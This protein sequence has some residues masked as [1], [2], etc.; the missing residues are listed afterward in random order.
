[1]PDRVVRD[2]I[3]D[4][5]RINELSFPAE[6]FYRRL[7]SVA[8]DYGRYEARPSLL[9][10]KLFPVRPD[11]SLVTT[12]QVEIWMYECARQQVIRLY[13]IEG[14][15]FLEIRNFGQRLRSMKS[16]YPAPP[17]DGECLTDAGHPPAVVS[18]SPSNDGHAPVNDTSM[19]PEEKGNEEK[20]NES[21]R[22]EGKGKAPDEPAAGDAPAPPAPAPGSSLKAKQTAMLS[23]Q[24]IFQEAVMAYADRYSADVLQ[25]FL[26]HWTEPNKSRT[27]M[28]FEMQETWDLAK[29]LVTWETRDQQW[30]KPR[31]QPAGGSTAAGGSPGIALPQ[32][33]D[34]LYGRFVEEAQIGHLLQEKHCD[35]L[36]QLGLIDIDERFLLEAINR[37]IKGLIGTNNASELRMIQAYQAGTWRTDPDCQKD[38]GNRT[39]LAKKLALYDFFKRAKALNLKTI[40][41]A[42]PIPAS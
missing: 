42:R 17:P 35:L 20:G 25:A 14:R 29:R 18:S 10:G 26:R 6:V 39:R 38:E 2:S 21:N 32:D 34:F 33:L 19:L 3:L 36:I 16:R 11:H 24:K 8:D 7:M 13:E 30:N 5:D 37:R 12:E 27:K 40:S 9:R 1:M 31:G 41:D 4:S 15:L 28:K 22:N 23:R